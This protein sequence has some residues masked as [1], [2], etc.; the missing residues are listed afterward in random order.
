MCV[1]FPARDLDSCVLE[2]VLCKQNGASQGPSKGVWA[3]LLRGA[4]QELQSS[5]WKTAAG[6]GWRAR[7]EEEGAVKPGWDRTAQAGP[8]R[9]WE[10]GQ[11]VCPSWNKGRSFP[12]PCV[13]LEPTSAF[14][15]S[16][17][18]SLMECVGTPR[19]DE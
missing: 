15:E 1:A 6:H 3:V 7:T 13:L 14:A 17:R 11:G 9:Q 18:A 8:C 16:Q 2:H 5:T 4:G 12:Q 19:P 10:E